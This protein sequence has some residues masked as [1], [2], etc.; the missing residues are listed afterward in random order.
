[1]P[2][3]VLGNRLANEGRRRDAAAEG[4]ALTPRM[5][6]A[7]NQWISQLNAFSTTSC[8]VIARF[9]AASE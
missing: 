5:S 4:R 7:R 2:G 9:H 1:V 3:D 6:A 8:T